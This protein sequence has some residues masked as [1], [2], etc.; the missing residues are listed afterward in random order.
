MSWK[1]RKRLTVMAGVKEVGTGIHGGTSSAKVKGR[2]W[3][4][5]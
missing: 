3:K 1:E 4:T 5:N 2:A